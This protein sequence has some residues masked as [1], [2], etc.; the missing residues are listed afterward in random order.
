MATVHV[1]R[2]LGA[3]G[4][5]RTVAIKRL[6][7]GYARD[8]EFV[9]MLL[10]EARIAAVLRHPNVVPTLDV[11][12]E[13]DE[14]LVVM[15]YVEGDSVAH[16]VKLLNGQPVPVPFAASI[17]AQALHGLHAAHIAKDRNGDPLGVVHRD[18]SPQNILV[19]VDG[20][21][22]VLDFGIAKA[23]S[24]ATATEDGQIKGKTAYM[25]PEQLNY[26]PVDGRTDV[27]AAA[28][29]LWELLCGRRLFFGDSPGESFARALNHHAERVE[30]HAPHVSRALSDVVMK[31]LARDITQRW[32]SAEAMAYAIE[33]T[34]AAPR[35]KDVGYWVQTI[36]K[37]T[38]DDRARLV[39]EVEKSS[40]RMKAVPQAPESTLSRAINEAERRRLHA[41]LPTDS[42]AVPVAEES[43]DIATVHSTIQKGPPRPAT[44]GTR[45]ALFLAIGGAGALLVAVIL[46]GVVVMRSKLAPAAASEK[47]AVAI[48]AQGDVPTS[49]AVVADAAP[50]E[51]VA[52]ADAAPPPLSPSPSP[53]S[54]RATKGPAYKKPDCDPPYRVDAKG[55][56][57]FKP[58]CP[59]DR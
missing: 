3:A 56:R 46:L 33:E 7:D 36:A 12:A 14:L 59:L 32:E 34:I 15:E 52:V 41:E 48:D 22:R 23:A 54:V 50:L 10:D 53:T 42:G 27:Y 55:M 49:V 6:H 9:S 35:A 58:E 44:N 45:A 8:P 2:L 26:E 47:V 1:G 17:V 18:V 43:T 28:I 37:D 39:S 5:S 25:A 16:L 20:A 11:V 38:L 13:D 51:T 57:H 29:V 4:F 30:V 40:H 31:G 19:G 21:A 24:R